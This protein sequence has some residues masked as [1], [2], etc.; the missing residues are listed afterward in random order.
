MDGMGW[1]GMGWHNIQTT[2]V[3][4]IRI[5]VLSINSL[6]QTPIGPMSFLSIETSPVISVNSL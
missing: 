5:P 3:T 2:P 6:K 4:S 1:D